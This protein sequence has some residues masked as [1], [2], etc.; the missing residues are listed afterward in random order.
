MVNLYSVRVRFAPSPTGYLHIGGARTALFNYLFARHHDGRF[1][2]RIEDTDVSRSKK[3]LTEVILRS[4]RWLGLEWDEE[5]LFQSTRLDR[6]RAICE[7]LMQKGS[8]YPCFC[9]PEELAEKREKA[10]KEYRYDRKCLEL[11][12]EEIQDKL[13]RG[14]SRVIRF[15]VPDGETTFRDAIRGV[16]TVHNEQIDDFVLL[17]S[18]N[19]PVYQ[20]AVVV[21]DHG[22]GIT[23][24][25]RG[26]DHLS[27]TPK[28]IMIYE[29]LG[30]PVP[31]F[32]H[33]PLILGPDKKRL[34]KRH[35]ATSVE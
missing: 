11:S 21:D 12:K 2:L 4:L 26:D 9:T 7:E 35:G 29:A 8:A 25:I 24:V 18:D 10:Q 28:Q 23:H 31:E 3:E 30:W 13:D 27:N 14:V 22:M 34:S 33:V 6:Y 32:A 17:R 1:L 20:L 16:V 19:N 15:R 5:P